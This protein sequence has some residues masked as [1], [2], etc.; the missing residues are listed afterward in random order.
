MK[1]VIFGL[2]FTSEAFLRF[3]GDRFSSILATVR[4][5]DKA[6][7][8]TKPGCEVVVF[9]GDHADPK[10]AAAL[11]E[12]DAVLI[13]A[14]P[15]ETGDPV[16]RRFAREIETS[17]SIQWIGYLSTIGVYGDA[18]GGWVDEIVP[19]R[20]S[21]ARTLRR[22]EVEKAWLALGA[23]SAKPTQIFR[24]AGIY[25]PGRNPIINLDQRA[26]RVIKKGQVFNRI[27]VD[28]I[29]QVLLAS[30][31]RPRNGAIYN[32]SD[33]EPAP[34]QDVLLYAAEVMGREPPPE[35]PFEEAIMSE[36]ARSFYADNKRVSNLL[37]H[38]EL[39][40]ALRYPTYR[41]GVSA[42]AVAS[43]LPSP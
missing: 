10:I 24:L 41:E 6:A 7:R 16:L 18:D 5:P 17:P 23:R 30:M 20:P 4:T 14:G 29:A 15:D 34:P 1:L 38:E 33:D 40:V 11:N 36:M 22:V 12:A 43:K 35:V 42:L 39:G 21:H 28:D 25:G 26:Q 32:V 8:N 3:A 13:S 37:I 27:H 19:P 31:A 2:G 9:N